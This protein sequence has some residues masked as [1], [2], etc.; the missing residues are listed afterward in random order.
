M[1]GLPAR[2]KSFLSFKL[3]RYL[4]WTGYRAKIFNVGEYRR[5][6][7]G[8]DSSDSRFFDPHCSEFKRKRERLAQKCFS[9]LLTWLG[10]EGDVAIY[11]AT[12]V[13]PERRAYLAKRCLE[14]GFNFVFVESI[15]RNRSVLR[16][17]IEKKL[18][19][20]PDYTGK[21][22]KKAV[23]DFLARMV[24]Y[25][26]VYKEIGGELPCLKIFD[27]GEKT[28]KNFVLADALLDDVFCFLKSLRLVE[29][30]V[31]LARHGETFFNLE[32]KIGGNSFLTREG[33]ESAK[34]LAMGFGRRDIRVFTSRKKRTMESAKFFHGKTVSLRE[35]DE[36][37]SGICDG[38]SYLEISRKYPDISAARG[39]DKF[40]FRYP[41]GE[42]YADLIRRLKRAVFKIESSREDTL[43]IGHRAV[44]RC[45]FSYFIPIPKKDIPYIDIPLGK[46]IKITSGE[47]EYGYEILNFGKR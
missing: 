35:L 24:H 1:S 39:K 42:S 14:S 20:S 7:F 41:A 46:L 13:T 32:E 5:R 21:N 43:V 17:I 31:Y 45:L 22:K 27:F 19:S 26:S 33:L 25:E 40:G 8:P 29:K 37:N 18:S 23:K 10:K 34:K 6:V 15:C 4:N 30:K 38:M 44:N 3:N 12:N 28:V 47:R 36:I 2:G 16:R 11:D 9:D